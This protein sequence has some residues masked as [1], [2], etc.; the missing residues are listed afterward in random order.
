[1]LLPLPANLTSSGFSRT[2]RVSHKLEATRSYF[3][4]NG[5]CLLFV[6]F[7][8]RKLLTALPVHGGVSQQVEPEVERD[9]LLLKAFSVYCSLLKT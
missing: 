9:E 2:P 6:F 3:F 7:Y 8:P 4:S 1:M 5:L